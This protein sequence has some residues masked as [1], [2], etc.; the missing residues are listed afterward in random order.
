MNKVIKNVSVPSQGTSA[1]RKPRNV[2][3]RWS[4][5][6]KIAWTEKRT[7]RRAEEH[8]D[9]R[10]SL[11]TPT[12]TPLPFPFGGWEYKKRRKKERKRNIVYLQVAGS[13]PSGSRVD[14]S[15]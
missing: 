8:S 1:R 12:P 4:V 3:I 2:K 15:F 7:D 10:L 5:F 6:K 14:F 13:R 9:S 11:P